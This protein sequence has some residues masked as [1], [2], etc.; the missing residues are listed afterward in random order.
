MRITDGIEIKIQNEKY[1]RLLLRVITVIGFSPKMNDFQNKCAK[2]TAV[3]SSK[4]L[5]E[6]T[7]VKPFLIS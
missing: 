6:T 1:G 5:R 4:S 3:I 2:R 7:L